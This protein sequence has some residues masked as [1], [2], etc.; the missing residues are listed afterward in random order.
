MVGNLH[1]RVGDSGP[2]RGA[3]ARAIY[4][5]LDI[6]RNGNASPS[7]QGQSSG[8]QAGSDFLTVDNWRVGAY[9]GSLDGSAEVSGKAGGAFDRVGSDDLRSNFLGG[10]ATWTG[11]NGWYADTVLQA[12][13]H[14][15]SVRPDASLSASGKARSYSASLEAGKSFAMTEAWSIEPQAQLIYLSSRFDEVRIVGA[16][17]QQDSDAGWI[18]RIGVRIK[19]DIPTAAGRLQ[20]Y[21]RA[22]VYRAN[23]GTD[24]VMFVGP[25]SAI[26]SSS[27]SGYTST[28]VAG[29]FTL[30]LTPITMV[31]GEVGRL[32][33]SGGNAQVKSSLQGSLGVRVSW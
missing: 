21:A 19:G 30:V 12:G 24:M 22:N 32:F 10:Y 18:G 2:A 3:W 27:A 17:V 14:R 1:R 9:V 11:A 4:S 5:D 26:Q 28:E 25:V 16:S 29:G 15:Y 6:R 23:A 7:S 31:Y 8:L 20:P 13:S 33:S